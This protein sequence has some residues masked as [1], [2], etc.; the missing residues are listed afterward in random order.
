MNYYNKEHIE[1]FDKQFRINLVNSLSGYKSANLIATKSKDEVTNVAIYSSVIHLSSNPPL[2]GFILRPTSVER[3][4]YDNLVSTGE[5][6]VNHIHRDIIK[7][8]HHTSAKYKGEISEFDKTNLTEEYQKGF[9]PP[10]VKEAR[11][12]MGCKLVNYYY[13]K[14]NKCRMIVGEIEHLFFDDG[15]EEKDGWLNLEKA[16]TVAINGLD[17]YAETHLIDRFDHAKPDKKV[18]SIINEEK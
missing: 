9:F 7:E 8:A 10:F 5:F 3:N 17:G 14:E 18:S 16:E 13:I 2:L 11:I 4:T 1:K 15:I 12:K 6:T